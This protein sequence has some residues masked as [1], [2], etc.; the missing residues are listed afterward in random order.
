MIST[1]TGF[2]D[3]SSCVVT[4]HQILFLLSCT[5]RKKKI[6]FTIKTSHQIITGTKITKTCSLVIFKFHVEY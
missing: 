1:F 6:T 2:N 3:A 4:L 5:Q